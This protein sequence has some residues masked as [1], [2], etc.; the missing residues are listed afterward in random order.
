MT[1]FAIYAIREVSERCIV[2]AD[3]KEEAIEKAEN[4]EWEIDGDIS[5]EITS[6][7]KIK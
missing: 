2:K 7:D 5:F 6:V 4:E 3:S 1:Y